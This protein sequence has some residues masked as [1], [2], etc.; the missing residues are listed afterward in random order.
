[1]LECKHYPAKLEN[2]QLT[3]CIIYLGIFVGNFRAAMEK[4]ILSI[5][6]LVICQTDARI[7]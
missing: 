6:A 3:N 7:Y 1:M 2:N 5:Y 4:C